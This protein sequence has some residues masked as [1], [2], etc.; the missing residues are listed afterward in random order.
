MATPLRPLPTGRRPRRMPGTR[1]IVVALGVLAAVNLLVI[2]AH[3]GGQGQDTGP[4][5]PEGVRFLVPRP[6]SVIR[7]Q[8]DVGAQLKE[9]YTGALFIDDIRIPDSDARIDPSLGVVEF[10]PGPNKEITALAPGHHYA[11][12]HFWP[13]DKGDEDAARAAGAV[14]SYTWQ[15]TAG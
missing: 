1:T 5:L 3:T 9:T 4:P 13:Q 15:F 2:A 10:R 6:G 14:K 8:D 11:T 12:I 7:P